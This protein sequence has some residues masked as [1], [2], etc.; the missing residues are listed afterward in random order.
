MIADYY[1]NVS[2]QGNNILLRGV[3]NN[4]RINLKI[5]YKPKFYVPTKKGTE[6]RTLFNEPLEQLKFDSIREARDFRKKYDEVENFNIYGQERFEYAF[7]ADEFS[8][9]ID[10]NINDLVIA[11]LDIETGKDEFGEFPDPYRGNGPITAI[12]IRYLNGD[13]YLFGCKDYEIQGEE[14]YIQCKDEYDL[15]K[16]FLNHWTTNYCDVVS[17]WNSAGYDIP[18]IINRFGIVLGEDEVKKLSPWG[19]VWSRTREINGKE[20][21]QYTISGIASLD[22]LELYKWFAPEGKSKE[23]YKLDFIASEELG[24]RKLSYEEY[25]TLDNLYEQNYQRFCEY[26]L[27]DTELLIK[28]ENKLKLIELACS[29]AYETKSN[30]EDVFTQTRM[31]DSLIYSYLLKDKIIIPPKKIKEKESAYEGAFVKEPKPGM[32]QWVVSLDA[33]SLYPSIIIQHNISPECIVEPHQYTDEMRRIIDSGVTVKKILNQEIDLSGLKDVTLTPNGQFFRTDIKGF[34]PKMLEQM[35]NERKMFKKKMLETSSEYEKVL[36]KLEKT[37]E[38]KVLLDQK[39]DLYRQ[40]S[41]YNNIQLSRKLTL[42]SIYGSYGSVFFRFFDVRLAAA[43]TTAGQMCIHW[44]HDTTNNYLNKVLKT[45]ND[46]VIA[47]DTDSIILCLEPLIQKVGVDTSD[48]NKVISFMEKVC[49]DKIQPALKQKFQELSDYTHACVPKIFL[50]LEAVAD[51][52]IWTAKKRYIL[53]VYSNEGVQYKEPK[54]KIK[55]LEVIKSSTPYEIR[56]KMRDVIRLIM[57]ADEKTV[58][59]YIADFR[60]QFKQLPIEN[61]AFPRGVNNIGKYIDSKTQYKL[62]TPIHVKGSILYN[63]YLIKKNLDKTYP[64]IQSGDKIKFIYLKKPN[65]LKNE[66]ISFPIRLPVEFGL[67]DYI[68]KDKQFNKTFIDPIVVILDCIG[69]KVEKTFTLDDFWG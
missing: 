43:V 19:N 30:F 16:K 52:A 60:N 20:T 63:D 38:D 21:I 68:D 14:K 15:C 45:T 36:S 32:Y 55:G 67:H 59:D 66:V 64:K 53:N 22:Y 37:P 6:F 26:N 17:G 56:Q 31:W 29:L 65:P 48:I 2:V 28:L 4:R 69:W 10:W 46:F 39:D 12:S 62:G 49:I 8:E 18:Y 44:A 7:I 58:Q 50:K 34:I 35:F 41:K 42:V 40:I 33:E 47:V 11:L 23:S 57:T 1:S 13:V 51:R 9:S 24:E 5:Q 61:I 25:D 27:V 3:K 54:L